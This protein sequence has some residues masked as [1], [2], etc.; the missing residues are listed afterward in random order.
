MGRLSR[1][2]LLLI[3][4]ASCTAEQDPQ[5]DSNDES[6]SGEANACPGI[7][8]LTD[9]DNC[10]ECGRRCINSELGEYSAGQCV[11]GACTPYWSACH[12]LESEPSRSCDEICEEQLTV[13]ARDGCAGGTILTLAPPPGGDVIDECMLGSTAVF[14]SVPLACDIVPTTA[15][16]NTS[17]YSCCCE[18]KPF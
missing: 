3:L 1:A 16:L 11:D 8:L 10:G 13:C 5:A 17:R 9:S 2:I 18:N 7:D 6:E 15:D 14:S 4:A 12:D